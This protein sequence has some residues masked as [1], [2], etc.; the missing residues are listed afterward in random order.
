MLEEV[1]KAISVVVLPSTVKFI[2]GPLA[3]KAA[4]LHILSTMIGTT[5]GMML[6]VVAFTYFG[7]FIRAQILRYFGKKNQRLSERE[8]PGYLRKHGL[9]GISFSTPIILTPIGGTVLAVSITP[10]KKRIIL[11]MFFSALFWSIVITSAVY[12]GYDAILK[13]VKQVQPV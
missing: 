12:F 3:G 9:P 10:N 6:S 13:F 11:F 5:A 1:L 4:G 7:E 2:F 8:R